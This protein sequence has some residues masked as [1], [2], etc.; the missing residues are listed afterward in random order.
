MRLVALYLFSFV[1]CIIGFLFIEYSFPELDTQKS[2]ALGFA[3]ICFYW[4]QR[5]MEYIHNDDKK[6]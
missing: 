5:V 4:Y 1:L 3:I 6:E 2:I